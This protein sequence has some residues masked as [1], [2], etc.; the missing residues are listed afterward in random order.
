MKEKFKRFIALLLILVIILPVQ[1]L[2]VF[3]ET[4]SEN[5]VT[6][7]DSYNEQVTNP[8]E[9]KTVSGEDMEEETLP[10]AD[11]TGKEFSHVGVDEEGMPSAPIHHCAPD[12]TDFSYVYFGSYPQ[13]EVTDSAIIAAIENAISTSG[14]ESNADVGIDVIVDGIKYRRISRSDTNYSGY[15]GN[16]EYRYFKWEKIRW[17][18]LQNDGAT[19]FVMADMALDCKDYHD[20]G[21]DITWEDSSIRSWLNGSFYHTA[22]NSGEQ[23]A[24]V[25]QTVKN[26]DNPAYGTEGGN[27]TRDKVYLLSIDEVTKETYGFCSD[28]NI[29]SQSRRIKASDY[30]NA[31]GTHRDG[32]DGYCWW[33]L[34]SPGCGSYDA[35]DVDSYGC[36]GRHGDTVHSYNDGVCPALH[37][38]LQSDLGSILDDSTVRE[39]AIQTEGEVPTNPIHH[40]PAKEGIIDCT[41]WNYVYFGSYPQSEVTDSAIIAAIE[42]A[43]STSGEESDADMG[44]DVWADGIKYRRISKNDTNDNE[45]FDEV[46]N[47]GYR[48]FKWE[49]IKW[50]VLNNDGNTLFVVADKAID[51]KDYNEENISITWETSTIRNWLNKGF[52]NVAFS[53]S[54]QS[55]I[56]RQNV[57][58]KDN[59]YYGTEGGNN[60]SDN[61]YLLSISEVM[62]EAYGFC[63]D[64]STDSTSR[65]VQPSNYARARGTYTYNSGYTGGN[66]NCWWWLRSPGDGGSNAARV[67]DYGYVYRDGRSVDYSDDGVCPALHINL[68]SDLWS[69]ADD[70]VEEEKILTGIQASKQKT[71]YEQ[72]ENLN[73]DDLTVTAVYEDSKQILTKDSYV[74][75]TSGIDMDT[76]GNYELEISY[77]E[78]DVTRKTIITITVKE[79]AGEGTRQP[80]S[81]IQNQPIKVTKLTIAAPSKKLAAG[82]KVKLTLKVEPENASEKTVAWKTS[83]EKYATID[84]N[85]KLSLKKAGAGKTV[86]VTATAKDGSGKKATIK[87][88]IMKHAV[89]SI[90]LKAPSKTLEAGKSMTVKATVTTTGKSVNKT[91]KWQSSNTKYATVNQKGKVTA[92]KAGKGKTVTITAT[93]TD[94]SNKKAK[95]KLKIK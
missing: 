84:E 6:E 42:N 32:Y 81:S 60:T 64:D 29:Y 89:K 78:K 9:P 72:G 61:V 5:E 30:A 40:C 25:E 13:S 77:T 68:Q 91:L 18:V 28:S 24:V 10:E 1:E 33:W 20:A 71:T 35:A 39:N 47:N 73:L 94:G 17:K 53:S 70:T 23:E 45:Y 46:S 74:V 67:G 14:T 52:Y 79:K 34:R 21:G 69:I 66:D 76:P 36:V 62:D 3:A 58:N 63:S 41:D 95:V 85:G 16:S 55:A 2:R 49:Q 75:N 43:I 7:E 57:V 51:C 15:F 37:I 12:Y 27:D 44:I 87:I 88:K 8:I 54:E 26:E 90:K 83:N 92:K 22:F 82:Q 48:Y 59:P 80:D 31:R 86:T 38:N 50:K 56:V 65:W 11:V 19:L 93:S 4:V